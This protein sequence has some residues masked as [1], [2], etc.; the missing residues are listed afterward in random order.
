MLPVGQ[1]GV[2]RALPE[3]RAGQAR[4]GGSGGSPT[5]C[6]RLRLIFPSAPGPSENLRGQDYCLIWGRLGLSVTV[7]AVWKA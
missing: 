6:R 7:T 3:A 2:S 4:V 5:G 1:A